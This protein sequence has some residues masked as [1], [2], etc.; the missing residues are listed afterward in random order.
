LA[1]ARTGTG[2]ACRSG[3]GKRGDRLG[4]SSNLGFLSSLRK[5]GP[6]PFQPKLIPAFRLRALRSA[7]SKPAEARKRASAGRRNER[8]E[9]VATQPACGPP[10][11]T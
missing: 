8:N 5:R 9:S 10:P 2:Q 6:N 11:Q 1:A 7:D 4:H 3:A